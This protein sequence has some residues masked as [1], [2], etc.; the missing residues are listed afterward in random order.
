MLG[1]CHLADITRHWGYNNE[2]IITCPPRNQD[3]EGK[4]FSKPTIKIECDKCFKRAVCKVLGDP[5]MENHIQLREDRDE[6][7]DDEF[8]DERWIH[9]GRCWPGRWI[10][11]KKVF[12]DR[13]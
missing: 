5:R 7:T 8:L 10:G 2:W 3:F 13:K 11:K 12:G 1:I 4:H 9:I 6:F